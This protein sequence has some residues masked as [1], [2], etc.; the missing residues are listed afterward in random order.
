[1]TIMIL[2]KVFLSQTTE[3]KSK[4]LCKKKLCYG[5]LGNISNEHNAK[6][7]A[8][9][10]MCKLCGGRHATVLHG[11]KTQ[12]YKKKG[13][14]EDTDTKE[15]KPEELKCALTN[16]RSD[17]IGMCI[18]PVQ[19]KSKDTSKTVHTYALLGSC[20][21]GTFILDQLASDLAIS[22]RKT[23]LSI[24]TLN[25]EFISNST[26]LEGLKVPSISEGNIE[27]LPLPRTFTRADLPVDND[28]I[29]KP[30]QLWK[31]KFLE[32]V[33]NQLTFS[34]DTSV[35]LLVGANGT[36]ALQP[37]KI[38]QSKNGG[39]YAFKTRLG[40]G[41]FG[42]V[43]RTKRNKVSCNQVAV[44]QADTK[45][46][47]RHFFQVKKE[48]KENHLPDMLQQ[49]YNH[50]FTKCQLLVNKDLADMSQEDLKFIETLKNGTEL[51]GGHCQVPLPFRKD[52]VNLRNNRSPAEKIFA[53]LKKRLSRNPQF[54]Q[55]Y[56]KFMIELIK[57][58]YARE[59]TTAVRAGKCWYLPHNAVYHPNK[60]W[61]D[62][63]SI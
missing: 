51:V 4:T 23:S 24:K 12:K 53:C 52:D 13:N 40:S 61:E 36:K 37:T 18:N 62:T 32:N 26:A 43:N 60:P 16:S 11:L 14:N 2:K 56:V 19:I 1:M 6:S 47:G 57:K 10:R 21:Q 30:S 5:Y 45:E 20:S 55:D 9:R 54:K 41:V 7:C 33:I 50:E 42:P 8:N 22:G 58:G 63:C 44:T 49:M 25:G 35:G 46:V 29:T 3:D 34:D 39:P 15:D 28:D 59:S 27:W 31:W 48:V 17:V 38:L